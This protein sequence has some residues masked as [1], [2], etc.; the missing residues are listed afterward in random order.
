MALLLVENGAQKGQ[1]FPLKEG[2]VSCIGRDQT[3]EV[4]LSDPMVSRRHFSIEVQNS[5]CVLRDLGSA[6]GTILNGQK[7]RER[8][9]R[10]GDRIVAGETILTLLS[11]ETVDPLLG[12]VLKGYE[13]VQRI[14]RGGMGTVYQAR[15][16]SL[17]RLVALKL[18]D[19]DLVEDPTFVGR[20]LDEARSAARLNHPNIVMVYDIDEAQLAGRRIVY[21]SMEYMAGG[22]VEDLL[23]REGPLPAER[24]LGIALQTARGLLFAEQVGMVHRDIKPG[25]LMIHESGTIKIGDLGIAARASKAG[26]MVSQHGGVSGSPHYIS[27]EQARGQDLDSRADIYSLGISLFQMLSGRPPF[28]G[29]DV[30]ELLRK[31]IREPPPRLAE[32]RPELHPSVP[33]LVAK[34]LEKAREGRP[35]GAQAL[36][37]ELEESLAAVRAPAPPPPAERQAVRRKLILAGTAGAALAVLVGLFAAGGAAWSRY[38]SHRAEQRHRESVGRESLEVAAAALERGALDE[39][40]AE[41]KDLEASGVDRDFPELAAQAAI[42]KA[43]LGRS[44]AEF[45]RKRRDEEA[46]RT[47]G[48]LRAGFP[49]LERLRAVKDLEALL[50]PIEEFGRSHSDTPA[51]KE[52]TA[53]AA[54][55]RAAIRALE[56]RIERGQSA[57]RSL[58]I[59]AES[60]LEADPPR[61]REAL[62]RL[63]EPPA[64][65]QG[66]PA[67][68]ELARRVEEVTA[69]MVRDCRRWAR[70]A[71]ETAAAGGPQEAL[72]RL[73]RL[74]D[75]VEGQGLASL[76]ETMKKISTGIAAGDKKEGR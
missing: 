66:T 14:G 31:Q 72:K 32:L 29:G 20:F 15:Q 59:T 27:P 58:F 65:I 5:A 18:L 74:R 56:G 39:A 76:E 13:I 36:I 41:I 75:R 73:E 45:G 43:R 49:E 22:S 19:P 44:K 8:T 48:E 40:A 71:G 6:N 38:R 47:W 11:Q 7:V 4:C 61:Y 62:A 55:V 26:S 57:L 68:V 3:A 33:P 50:T 70:E 1:R 30:R 60:F 53:E 52:A 34:M 35:A 9:L 37:A 46:D 28:V 25:N 51:A 63:R 10:L 24:A 21:Y 16:V 69:R 2:A 64:E 67:E 23:H 12:K 54:R 17:E 42:L